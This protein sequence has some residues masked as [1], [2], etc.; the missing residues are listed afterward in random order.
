M[1]FSLTETQEAIRELARRVFEDHATDERVAAATATEAWYDDELWRQLASTSLLGVAIPERHGGSGLGLTELCLLIE[2]AGRRVAPVPLAPCLALGALPL[3][4]WGAEERRRELLPAVASGEL[5]LTGALVE[6]GSSDPARPRTAAAR[7]GSSWRVRGEKT[8]VPVGQRASR[9]VV[10]AR[11]AED[12]DVGLFLVDPSGPGASLERQ[13]TTSGEPAFLL[14]LDGA[15]VAAEDVLGEVG[16]GGAER[17]RLLEAWGAVALGALQLGIAEGA[18][19]RT[20]EYTSTREQFGRP[21]GSFQAVAQRAAD[22]Y[23]DVEAL[24]SVLYQALWRLSV[25]RDAERAVAVAKWWACRAGHRVAH[26]AQHL[27]GGIGADL[28]YPIHRYF[29]WAKQTEQS[30]GGAS[31]WLARLGTLLAEGGPRDG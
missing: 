23:I 9:V 10:P 30:L 20:A 7:D 28:A 3:A 8:C 4:A 31:P 25:G 15:R 17:V 27:H 11:V 19:A 21:I 1:D 26:T 12:G 22:A 2:E 24:R 6:V 13:R 29:L 5:L 14:R 18:L 16:A